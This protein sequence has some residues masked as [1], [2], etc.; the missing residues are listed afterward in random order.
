M[1]LRRWTERSNRD[2]QWWLRTV[3]GVAAILLLLW[4]MIVSRMEFGTGDP[5]QVSP[6]IES[7]RGTTDVHAI[8]PVPDGEAHN[9]H[10][11]SRRGPFLPAV[12][13]FIV[14]ATLLAGVWYL[15]VYKAGQKPRAGVDRT[16][17]TVS[18]GSGNE[19]KIMDING[20]VWV[21]GVSLQGPVQLLHRYSQEEWVEAETN[22]RSVEFRTFWNQ[23]R[24]NDA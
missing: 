17:E 20:E 5:D 14:L 1:D 23:V 24:G 8:D 4:L 11:S 10:A 2:P 18:L 12:T 19:L 22:N 7:V 15:L 9:D 21:V 13:T 16:K 3:L 6:R